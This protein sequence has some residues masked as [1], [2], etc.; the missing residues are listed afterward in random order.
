MRVRPWP[1]RPFKFRNVAIVGWCL[2]AAALLQPSRQFGAPVDGS[3]AR[4]PQTPPKLSSQRP[5]KA[6][7]ARAV[8]AYGKLPLGFEANQG[9]ADSRVHFL[10]R[11]SG[12]LLFLTPDEAVLALESERPQLSGR[13]SKLPQPGAETAKPKPPDV[14]R[15]QLVGGNAQ[16]AMAGTDVLP[17]KSNYFFSA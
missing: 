10:S 16:A 12:Y 9:Q 8:A 17:G 1:S 14:L 3:A 6:Q 7:Q 2:L 13:T 15:M 5:T 11:G 4:T